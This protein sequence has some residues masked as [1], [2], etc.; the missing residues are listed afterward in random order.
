M[1]GLPDEIK[2]LFHNYRVETIDTERD[3]EFVI[4]TVLAYGDW[5]ELEWAFR[6]Y[7]WDRIQQVVEKDLNGLN[8][9]P[10]SV[11][12]FWS[13]VFWGKPLPPQTPRE[14]WAQTRLVDRGGH[15]GGGKENTEAGN[16]DRRTD[17]RS[18]R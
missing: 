11:L 16:F 10:R 6:T 3:A 5:E 15:L 18:D 17:S 1:P 8:S 4:W 12:N 9:L 2:P 14:R 7:G 13:I